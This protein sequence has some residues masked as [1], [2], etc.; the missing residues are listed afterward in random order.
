MLSAFPD[1][2]YAMVESVLNAKQCQ[3]L[4]DQVSTGEVARA[5][6]RNLLH[7]AR[8]T[9]L[10]VSLKGNAAIAAHLPAAAVAVQCTL[11]DKSPGKN[12]LVALHQDL[13]IPV[14]Q[15]TTHPDCTGWSEKEGVLFVQPP[16]SV[17]NSLVA[18][19]VHLDECGRGAGALRVVPSSHRNGRLTEGEA[20]EQR[21]AHGEVEL[22][23]NRGDALL[24]RPLLLH[25][26]S[27]A[28][29]AVRRRVLHF[30]F[31]PPELPHGLTWKNA[32]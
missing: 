14:R 19:R 22:F 32:V 27:K 31:G 9:R 23:A 5:G 4:I 3:A 24:M 10:A 1:N 12:W 25:A 17:L 11:F 28:T 8:C 20:R 30:V 2:G 13:S 21:R 6:S 29:A 18:V 26:S 16:I 15:R 7:D